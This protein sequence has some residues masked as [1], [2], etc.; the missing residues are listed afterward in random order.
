MVRG[1]DIVAEFRIFFS[2]DDKS[3]LLLSAANIWFILIFSCPD[4]FNV[5]GID[6]MFKPPGFPVSYE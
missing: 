4:P 2:L 5:W 3:S 6:M 1:G